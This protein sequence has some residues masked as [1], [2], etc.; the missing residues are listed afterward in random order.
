VKWQWN[1]E[2]HLWQITTTGPMYFIFLSS[3]PLLHHDSIWVL[4]V[5]S[6]LLAN[7][8]S[9]VRACLIIWLERFCGTLKEDDRWPLSIQSSLVHNKEASLFSS[10]QHIKC[11]NFCSLCS[12]NTVYNMLAFLP[13]LR[14][15]YFEVVT[16]QQ[17]S[18]KIQPGFLKPWPLSFHFVVTSYLEKF[19]SWKKPSIWTELNFD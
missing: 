5:I 11:Q 12:L 2:S 17:C 4:P 3:L 15:N 10:Y 7:T 14:T 9:P 1:R 16:F 8:V 13:F 19:S 18:F 6:L